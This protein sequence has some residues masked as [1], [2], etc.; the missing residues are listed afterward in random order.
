MSHLM[1]WI[2]SKDNLYF[3][4]LLQF[5][6]MNDRCFSKFENSSKTRLSLKVAGGSWE[7]MLPKY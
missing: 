5:P 2:S 6:L 4:L 7:S 3:P 1:I